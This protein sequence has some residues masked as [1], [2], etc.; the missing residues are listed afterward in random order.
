MYLHKY[1][2]LQ[3]TVTLDN[4]D[5][6]QTP[7]TPETTKPSEDDNTTKPVPEPSDVSMPLDNSKTKSS[8]KTKNSSSAT[9]VSSSKIKNSPSFTEV[10]S[11]T[12]NVGHV[13]RSGRK[14]KPKKYSDYEN[15]GEAP[16]R[17]RVSKESMKTSEKVVGSETDNLSESSPN[18]RGKICVIK[19]YEMSIT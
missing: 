18:T 16:K 9:E 2:D 11:N 4:N 8:S 5:I 14:I 19:N 10:S 6:V 12:S 13:S 17:S 15:D 7:Q 1:I 3:E